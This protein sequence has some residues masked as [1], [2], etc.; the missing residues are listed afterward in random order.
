MES[1]IEELTNKINYLEHV[2]KLQ[3]ICLFDLKERVEK[4]EAIY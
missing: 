1:N 4:L 3:N 2:I